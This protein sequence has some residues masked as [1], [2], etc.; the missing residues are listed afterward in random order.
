MKGLRTDVGAARVGLN[1]ET[2]LLT[3]GLRVTWMCL[4]LKLKKKQDLLSAVGG[5]RVFWNQWQYRSS[6]L[7]YRSGTGTSCANISN[8]V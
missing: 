7:S 6:Y 2:W 5:R 4:C 3:S 1:C 8:L